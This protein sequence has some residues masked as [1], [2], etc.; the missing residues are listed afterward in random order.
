MNESNKLERSDSTGVT[1]EVT[2]AEV[3]AE[4]ERRRAARRATR[5][6]PN[7]IVIVADRLV[8]WFSKHWLATFNA[9][10]LLYVGLPILAPVL[11]H[12]SAESPA[13]IVYLVY[14]PLCHQLPQR[15]FFLFGPQWTY[16]ALELMERVEAPIG[17]G[18]ATRAFIGNEA[19]GYKVALCQRDIAIY[20]AILLFGFAYGLLRRRWKISPLPWWAYIGVGI[21]PL[22]VDGGYQLVSYVVPLFWPDGP[23]TPH[24]T[25]PAMRVITGA[26]FGLATVWLAYPIFQETM[27]ELQESLHQRLGRE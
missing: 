26:L 22:L 10:C 3:L 8:F 16:T 1:P 18:T 23:I 27:E 2:T 6:P 15:S 13:K 4:V 17:L 7:R 5:Q 24:E 21:V 14:R 19:I 12:L 25:T 11:M 20:G 9:F